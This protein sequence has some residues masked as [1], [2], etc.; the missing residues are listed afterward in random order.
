[1]FYLR[2][3][4]KE[5]IVEH[6]MHD[7]FSNQKE[8]AGQV[9][10]VQTRNHKLDVK[11]WNET[12]NDEKR[13]RQKTG[14]L[15]LR[16]FRKK[17]AGVLIALA[18]LMALLV[19]GGLSW[20]YGTY[21]LCID[22]EAICVI[23]DPEKGQ[24]V[25]DEY[26]A[27]KQR[28]NGSGVNFKEVVQLEQGFYLDL[29]AVST[30]GEFLAF[31]EAST[32]LE[33]PAVTLVVAGE[34]WL[35]LKDRSEADDFL[36]EMKTAYGE[37]NQ[38]TAKVTSLEF[39]QEIEMREEI[40]PLEDV[41]DA[42]TAMDQ[43][44]AADTT[45]PNL[46]V[47]VVYEYVE[48][49]A[50]APEVE[51]IPD[52]EALAGRQEIAEVGKEGKESRRIRVVEVNGEM[53]ESTI[54]ERE[55]IEAPGTTI[56]YEGT[57][58]ALSLASRG[59]SSGSDIPILGQVSAVFGETGAYW[60]NAHTGLDLAAE[61]GTPIYVV[62]AGE[63][64]FAGWNDAYGNLVIVDHGNGVVTYYGHQSKMVVKEGDFVARGDKLGECGSTGNSSGPHLH[65]EVRINDVP[66]DPQTSGLI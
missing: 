23:Q 52:D 5:R 38:P 46:E 25:I 56:I 40:V 66:V 26:L 39:K 15:P 11:V 57:R 18:V 65:F 24:D 29:P 19:Y 27:S 44:S 43:M 34:P 58:S 32:H 9:C 59:D 41:V 4:K 10:G 22:D 55:V 63:V 7:G 54:V 31:L 6:F 37:P 47:E 50:I 36:N 3:R 64:I 16:C 45:A 49:A 30:D 62:A 1:M 13:R 33:V 8:D 12:K 60:H 53:V 21:A 61:V 35:T 2:K 48:T 14:R 42:E 20:Q 17:S 51:V 28:D